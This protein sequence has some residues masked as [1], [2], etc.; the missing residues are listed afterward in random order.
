LARLPEAIPEKE[1]YNPI[2]RA[3]EDLEC[4]ST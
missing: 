4:P 3:A 1:L 2:C